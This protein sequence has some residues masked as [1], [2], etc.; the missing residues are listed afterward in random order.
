MGRVIRTFP[1]AKGFVRSTLVQTKGSVIQ[2]PIDKLSSDGSQWMILRN[3]SFLAP[4]NFIEV[5]VLLTNN[6]GPIC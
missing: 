6:L 3:Y 1:D 2:R 4:L 5:T